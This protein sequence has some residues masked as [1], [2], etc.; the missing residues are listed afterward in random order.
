MSR[1]LGRTNVVVALMSRSTFVGPTKDA[2]PGFMA[3]NDICHVG[4]YQLQVLNK[5]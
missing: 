2:A 3:F 1:F 4:H 5:C